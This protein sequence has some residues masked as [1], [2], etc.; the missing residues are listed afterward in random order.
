[1]GFYIEDTDLEFLD[2]LGKGKKPTKSLQEHGRDLIRKVK[3]PA[4]AAK[5]RKIMRAVRSKVLAE[6]LSS[7]LVKRVEHSEKL[8]NRSLNKLDRQINTGQTQKPASKG[9]NQ[10][11]PPK[12]VRFMGNN[13]GG[14]RM[15]DPRTNFDTYQRYGKSQVKKY[16]SSFDAVMQMNAKMIKPTVEGAE[17]AEDAANKNK[18]VP[19]PKTANTNYTKKAL[20]AMKTMGRVI[21]G[22]S[23]IGALSYAASSTPVGDATMDGKKYKNYKNTQNK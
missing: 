22:S 19:K 20:N 9:A 6:S 13:S 7:N 23:I 15:G 8:F 2:K 12:N 21:K 14:Y 17:R 5:R 1:M 3:E 16:Q 10:N 11:N 4:K 18:D